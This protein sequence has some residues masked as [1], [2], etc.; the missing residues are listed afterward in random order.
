MTNREGLRKGIRVTIEKVIICYSDGTWNGLENATFVE[1][2]EEH[3]LP[4]EC[5]ADM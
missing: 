2:S 5:A 1:Y 3:N 4:L